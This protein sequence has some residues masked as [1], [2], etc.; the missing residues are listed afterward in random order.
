VFPGGTGLPP[1]GRVQGGDAGGVAVV[2]T[3]KYL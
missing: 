1:A 2:L 3:E